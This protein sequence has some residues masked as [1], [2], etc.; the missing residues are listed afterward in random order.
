MLPSPLTATAIAVLPSVAKA[1]FPAGRL[2][3]GVFY[4]DSLALHAIEFCLRE[5]RK[6]TQTFCEAVR[7]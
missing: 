5:P 7:G 6:A 4:F 1:L 2:A 3:G